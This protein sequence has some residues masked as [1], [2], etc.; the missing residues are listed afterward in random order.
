MYELEFLRMRSASFG[1]ACVTFVPTRNRWTCKGISARIMCT[2]TG[3][4]CI[5]MY[6]AR[7]VRA[8]ASCIACV[9]STRARAAT[10][11]RAHAATNFG[12]SEIFRLAQ[13][14]DTEHTKLYEVFEAFATFRKPFARSIGRPMTSMSR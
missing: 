5:C 11:G 3:H 6:L 8:R 7:C 10:T 12:V 1:S 13:Q 4:A 9:D 14:I 2:M